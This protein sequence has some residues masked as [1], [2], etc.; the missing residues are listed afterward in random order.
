MAADA[1]GHGV[2]GAY[3][4]AVTF[5]VAGVTGDGS[6]GAR[7][8]RHRAIVVP[9]LAPDALSARFSL[10]AWVDTAGPQT[11]RAVLARW[12][13]GEGG[14]ML[15][16]DEAGRYSLVAGRDQ[17]TLRTA[18]APSGSWEHLVAT[19][20]G[21]TLRLYRNAALIGSEPFSGPLGEPAVNL[22]V[23]G[24]PGSLAERRRR[25]GGRLRPPLVDSRTFAA[26]TGAAGAFPGRIRRA[27]RRRQEMSATG[28]GRG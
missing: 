3:V 1:S 19:W 20:D 17:T 13:P 26:T 8:P 25:R 9:G 12:L 24:Y 5:G 7:P 15:R 21:S 14:I 11:N 23:G 10:E 6:I 28:S 27:I 22:T 16:L 18:V 4:G 2:N